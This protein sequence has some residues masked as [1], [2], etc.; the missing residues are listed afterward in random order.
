MAQSHPIYRDPRWVISLL[1]ATSLVADAVVVLVATG[2]TFP[3]PSLVVGYA[4]LCSQV[5]LAAIW[6]GIGMSRLLLRLIGNVAVITVGFFTI[7]ASSASASRRLHWW[8]FG[9]RSAEVAGCSNFASCRRRHFSSAA[10]L[11]P[12]RVEE[13]P[14]TSA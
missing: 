4:L 8:R 1:V 12:S 14:P 2:A 7:N 9:Y 5:A 11:S 13:G 10:C 3:A 6:L